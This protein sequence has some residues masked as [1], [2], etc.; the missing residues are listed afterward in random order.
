MRRGIL[1]TRDEL[2]GLGDKLRRAPFNRIYERLLAK[3]SLILQAAPVTEQQWRAAWQTGRWGA[4]LV[5][6]RIAQG[7]IWDLLIAHHIDSNP[8]FRDRAIEELKHLTR[9]NAWVDPSHN[10][11]P[12][13]L[14]TAEAA[15]AATVALDWLVEDLTEADR[16]RITQAIRTKAL[17]PYARAV[18]A[19][20]WWYTC[21]HNWN[22]VLNCGCGL[23]GMALADDD[24]LGDEVAAKARKGL[25]YFF[26]ALGREGGWDEGIGY[27]GYAMRFV[28]LF[29]EALARLEDDQSIFHRRGMDATGLFGVYFSPHGQPASFGDN[30]NVP[31]YGAL[32]LLVKHYGLSQVAWW[33]D[34][35]AHTHDVSTTDVAAEGLSLLF[36]PRDVNGDRP[37]KLDPLKTFR[38]VGWAVLADAWPEPGMYAAVKTGD[39]S[40]NHAHHDMNSL[41]LQ[42]DGEMLLTDPEHPPFSREYLFESR[43]AFY[44]VQAR[45]HNTLVVAEA[46]HR[47]DAR[48]RFVEARSGRNYRWLAC[49]AGEACGGN[50]RF[51]RHVVLLV[52]PGKRGRMLVVLDEIETGTPEKVELFWHTAGRLDLDA[53]AARATIVGAGATL[54]FGFDATVDLAART[55]SRRT[56]RGRSDTA[57]VLTGGVM[58]RALV[59]SAFARGAPVGEVSCTEEQDRVVIRAD[60]AELRFDRTEQG[61]ELARA[62]AE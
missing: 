51:R 35:Y 62:R 28:V 16:R 49:D 1:A 24:P 53:D 42:V 32:Y 20:A 61:L 6:A 8:A 18:D 36:R 37:P 34:A 39:L 44:E 5:A 15:I 40:A 9:W 22:A 21:Y 17:E 4:A 7:R 59:A 3:C 48:G 50:V 41:Q 29:G 25:E 12:A 14:C 33:L 27:W 31:L 60:G 26:N 13:D 10:H 57:V 19:K 56:G 11:I 55:T 45:A 47:I 38:E 30:A 46:D 2:G 54:G 23:A 58:G 43:E 52:G